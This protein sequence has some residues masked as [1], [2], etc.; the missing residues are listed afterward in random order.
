MKL[1]IGGVSLFLDLS[2]LPHGIANAL[3]TGIQNL[4]FPG[5]LR[6]HIHL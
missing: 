4:I 5:Y 2:G 6:L 3:D 1:H